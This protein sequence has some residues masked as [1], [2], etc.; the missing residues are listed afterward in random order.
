M[1]SVDVGSTRSAPSD[2]RRIWFSQPHVVATSGCIGVARRS[3]ARLAMARCVRHRTIPVARTPLSG[4]VRSAPVFSWQCLGMRP[5]QSV[6][7]C[8]KPH[9]NSR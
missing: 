4:D 6:G 5:T 9:H 2:P 7:V 1:V 8:T 3:R